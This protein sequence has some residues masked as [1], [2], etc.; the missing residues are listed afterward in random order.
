[1]QR[2]GV[3]RRPRQQG[4]APLALRLRLRVQARRLGLQFREGLLEGRHAVR[5]RVA[6][7]QRLGAEGEAG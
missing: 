6:R 3:E 1:M 5:R 7:G 2:A 4:L